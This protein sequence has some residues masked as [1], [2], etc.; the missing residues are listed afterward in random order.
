M[1]I[2]P[3]TSPPQSAAAPMGYGGYGS[4]THGTT[5]TW[6]ESIDSFELIAGNPGTSDAR[7]NHTSPAIAPAT[8]EPKGLFGFIFATVVKSIVIREVVNEVLPDASSELRTAARIVAS[9]V[10]PG[11]ELG[12]ILGG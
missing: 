5:P 7:V 4:N 3:T 9:A 2:T 6:P 1:Q 12:N 10:T 11:P 8:M